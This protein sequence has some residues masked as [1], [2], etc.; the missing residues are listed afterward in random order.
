MHANDI[1]H[2]DLK[3]EN[4]IIDEKRDIKFIDFGFAAI[5]DEPQRIF[6]GTPIFMA[7]E[8]VQQQEY[9]SGPVDIW[10]LGIIL[11]YMVAGYFPFRKGKGKSD[12]EIFKKIC[13]GMF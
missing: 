12:K 13:I 5:F 7:P 6:C 8:I 1:A 9:V 2:W 10:A 4:L 11:Y 3:F